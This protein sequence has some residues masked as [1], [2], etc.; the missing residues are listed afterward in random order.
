M[1]LPKRMQIIFLKKKMMFPSDPS[2]SP[3]CLRVPWAFFYGN[4]SISVSVT[5]MLIIWVLI[6]GIKGSS[7]RAFTLRATSLECPQSLILD[8]LN[9]LRTLTNTHKAYIFFAKD[10]LGK[11]AIVHFRFLVR[12]L[13]CLSPSTKGTC[14][15]TDLLLNMFW[16][17]VN[18]IASVGW[19]HP[20]PKVV[21]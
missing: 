18:G 15:M 4:A 6:E 17:L 12:M 16:T 7:V 14:A 2:I 11:G 10:A 19:A 21:M 1:R 13:A 5:I 3:W 8:N 9:L 20:D